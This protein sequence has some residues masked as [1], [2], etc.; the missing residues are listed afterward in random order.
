MRFARLSAAMVLALVVTVAWAEGKL[1]L[2]E[3]RY[4]KLDQVKAGMT[5]VCRTV[6]AGTRMEEFPVEI[7]SVMRRVGPKRNLI[8]ARL[9]GPRLKETGIIMGMSGSPIY[10]GGKLI[11]ALAYAWSFATEPMAGITPIEEMLEIV[12]RQERGPA[13]PS[14]SPMAAFAAGTGD[15]FLFPGTTPMLDMK[16]PVLMPIKTPVVVSGL[17]A[18]GIVMLARRLEPFGLVVTP[19][20]GVGKLAGKAPPMLPGA[21]LCVQLVTGD[22]EVT[23]IGTLTERVGDKV[24]GMGH[25]FLG[26]GE[27]SAPIA[28]GFVHTIIPSRYMSLKIASP[29]RTVGALLRDEAPG[30]LGELG[31]AGDMIDVTLTVARGEEKDT[32]DYKVFRHRT[33]SALFIADTIGASLQVW[34]HFPRKVTVELSVKIEVEG[35]API[36]LV[37]TYSGPLTFMD[38]IL[39]LSRP[40]GMLADNPFAEVKVKRVEAVAR[41]RPG[42]QT[43]ALE[44]V[45]LNRQRFYPGEEVIAEV[46]YA[47]YQAPRQHVTYRIEI[48]ADVTPGPKLLI[49]SDANTDMRLDR[50]S[51]PHRFE[52][53]NI[54]E[55]VA[56]LREQRAN[57]DL[58]VR[59][60]A[61]GYGLEV[62]G[63]ELR[64]LPPSMLSILGGSGTGS[65]TPLISF[66]KK[67]YPTQWV[68]VGQVALPIL[69][70]SPEQ[71]TGGPR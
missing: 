53:E 1:L 36:E 20:G 8:L 9:G 64:E 29:V 63:E 23:A 59:L 28:S 12:Q 5:G 13:T 15:R 37:N 46:H 56:L 2:D 60:T 43:A 6:L 52:P 41:L 58:A 24:L 21:P 25:Q 44:S 3:S 42:E 34:E 51:S 39:D 61:L 70:L 27:A 17:S 33:L 31:K 62:E 14:T 11:G 45:E 38:I 66:L 54:E 55:L 68:L 65:S 49:F 69:V 18:Q 47:P 50:L 7:I 48:P 35:H 10:V 19:G 57:S 71:E 26:E 16:Q 67:T 40:V 32:Y 22:I 4:L 30:L